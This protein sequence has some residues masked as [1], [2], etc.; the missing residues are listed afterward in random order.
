MKVNLWMIAN[1]LYE[2]EPELHIP[3]QAPANLRSARRA[4]ADQ[5]VYVY[6]SGKDVICSAGSEGGHLLFRD[7]KCDQI[8][9]M[10]QFTFDF[11]DDW[12]DEV[13]Q[14]VETLDYQQ[15]I[16]KSWHVFHNPVLLLDAG[17]RLMARSD[18]YGRDEV[19]FDW[20]Y[21]CE[22]GE[23]AVS[24][25]QYLLE[26]GRRESYYTNRQARFFR[27]PENPYV[28]S[29]ISVLLYDG[30]TVLGRMNVIQKDRTL[31]AGDLLLADILVKFLVQILARLDGVRMNNRVLYP[32]LNKMLKG[33]EIS[34]S[35]IAYWNRCTGWSAKE[36]FQVVVLSPENENTDIR[37]M[38]QICNLVQNAL[39]GCIA[40]EIDKRVALVYRVSCDLQPVS[41]VLNDIISGFSL[42]AGISNPF[43]DV[44]QLHFY[45][46]QAVY[47]WERGRRK[48]EEKSIHE[49]Y[50][51]A[52]EYIVLSDSLEKS[53]HAVH[54]DIIDL[55]KSKDVKHINA[56]ET[57][58]VYL[59]QERSPAR[60][61]EKL[62]LHKNTLLYRLNK[63]IER[64]NCNLEDSY[65]REYLKLSI[66]VLELW[67][68][69]KKLALY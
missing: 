62:F 57:L 9:E 49:F 18:Q 41:L 42:R 4:Y 27:F 50:L 37:E 3:E 16:Q 34:D 25:I 58:R 24:V 13:L 6:Q 69:E 63:V 21:L 39:P 31:N 40:T 53:Y 54:P 8:F 38:I 60:T 52:R 51:W 32:V 2:L 33:Q 64:L 10:I 12:F 17:S 68:E 43:Y 47:A 46:E 23:S 59:E 30:D 66:M 61:A 7:A 55:R 28:S 48:M 67:D 20:Q 36:R 44:D 29:E 11:Y 56:L 5:C 45:Y 15:L 65:T 1:R 22:H 26:M 19:N 14:C 35:E